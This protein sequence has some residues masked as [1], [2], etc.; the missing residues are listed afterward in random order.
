MKEKIGV[1]KIISALQL[2]TPFVMGARW[3]NYGHCMEMSVAGTAAL[4]RFG[5]KAAPT[6][7]AAMLMNEEA[8]INGSMGMTQRQVYERIAWG[9]E[10]R[11]PFD[12]WRSK[13]PMLIDDESPIHCVIHVPSG[14][15]FF[16]RRS[17]VRSNARHGRTWGLL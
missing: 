14:S 4:K 17:H 9:D 13:H 5:V 11:Q 8:A 2:A 10:P 15:G 3:S 7:C 16:L 6:I 12:E 1:C